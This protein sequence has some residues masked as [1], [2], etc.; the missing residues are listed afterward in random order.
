MTAATLLGMVCYATLPTRYPLIVSDSSRADTWHAGLV[1]FGDARG[2]GFCA[3]IPGRIGGINNKLLI[4]HLG[5]LGVDMASL[6]RSAFCKGAVV[7]GVQQGVSLWSVP[8]IVIL[9]PTLVSAML[10]FRQGDKEAR[11]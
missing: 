1:D 5:R 6:L 2:V 10:V 4:V 9:L 3:L 11:V 8:V 7:L